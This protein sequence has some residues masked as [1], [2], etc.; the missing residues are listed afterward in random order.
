MQTT[1]RAH[2]TAAD[3]QSL[4]DI[5][6]STVYRMA[7]DGRLPAVRVGRQWRF[8]AEE[9]ERLY[10]LEPRH[11]SRTVDP[12]AA[13]HILEAVAPALR[14][15]MVVTD[16]QGLPITPIVNPTVWMEEQTD[17]DTVLTGCLDEW[18]LLASDLDLMPRFVESVFGFECAR[19][20]VRSGAELVGM[21]LAGGIAPPNSSN[22]RFVVLDG[23]D[24]AAVLDALPRVSALISQFAVNNKRSNP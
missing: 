6:R 3:V 5:D 22:S 15:M 10:D 24:R 1:T 12:V 7:A 16:L 9:M 17:P 2:L 13:C 23:P 21:V 18:R 4:L 20:F 14:V 11:G 19:A 8:P